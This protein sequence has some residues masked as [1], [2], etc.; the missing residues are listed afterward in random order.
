MKK[1]C[2]FLA[3]CVLVLTVAPTKAQVGVLTTTP[4]TTFEVHKTNNANVADGVLP[5]VMTKEE[6]ASKAAG[7]YGANQNGTMVYVDNITGGTTGT[8]VA[9]V[10]NIN[11]KGYYRFDSVSNTW[12][13]MAAPSISDFELYDFR[14]LTQTA[15][16][17]YSNDPNNNGG[18]TG[19]INDWL[20]NLNFTPTPIVVPPK[21]EMLLVYNL[22]QVI[23]YSI[24]MM[25]YAQTMNAVANVQLG[26]T[27]AVL[28]D[29]TSVAHWAQDHYPFVPTKF[30]RDTQTHSTVMARKSTTA[31]IFITNN[32][33]APITYNATA[34]L[35]VN[36]YLTNYV[37]FNMGGG[38]LAITIYKK[39][40]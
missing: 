40:L 27:F 8:S 5:P 15:D 38:Q 12:I 13:G 21:S 3:L 35:V 14:F 39:D 28:N 23:T 9:Q 36:M 34:F 2:F 6:L 17:N 31:P 37:N 24:A 32:T 26:T 33:T 25:S 16:I 22:N 7:V 19:F 11:K 4:Q 10:V 1:K 18:K 29:D 30:K 20:I